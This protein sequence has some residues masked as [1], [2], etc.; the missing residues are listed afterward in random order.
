MV[1]APTLM[2]AITVFAMIG[3][4]LYHTYKTFRSGGCSSCP[5]NMRK[6]TGR[7]KEKCR[8]ES[9]ECKKKS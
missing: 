6:G 5:E 3:L 1:N 9:G 7:R 8:C 4:A 2:A